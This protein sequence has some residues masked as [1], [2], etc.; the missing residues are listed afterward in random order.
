MGELRV[1][2]VGSFGIVRAIGPHLLEDLAE[3]TRVQRQHY[4]EQ[5]ELLKRNVEDTRQSLANERD[6]RLKFLLPRR[7]ELR[8]VR[9]LPLA[10]EYV[11]PASVEDVRS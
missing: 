11:V 10:V 3:E 5:L 1:L 2:L 7:S 8:E 6:Y 4:E 9:V